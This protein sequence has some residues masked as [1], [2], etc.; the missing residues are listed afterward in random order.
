MRQAE[1]LVFNDIIYA[2]SISY[3]S[4]SFNDA[5]AEHD[6]IAA[7]AVVDNVSTAST[8]FDLDIQHS[9]DGRSWLTR[10]DPNQSFP[11]SVVPGFSDITLAGMGPNTTY[12]RMC[13]DAALGRTKQGVSN[14]DG[15]TRG[16]I[17]GFVRFAMRVTLG[18]AHVKVYAVLRD[19]TVPVVKRP[20]KRI[21]L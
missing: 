18:F 13:S 2:G 5:L 12:A 8:G 17:L 15:G 3:T 16:P 14:G 4:A 6:M 9:C 20:R 7:M 21:G 1:L 10:T 19:T 11:P